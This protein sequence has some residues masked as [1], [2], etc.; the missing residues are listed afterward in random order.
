MQIE[1]WGDAWGHIT[2]WDNDSF[3]DKSSHLPDSRESIFV[4]KLYF[5]GI[6]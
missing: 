4:K 6:E 2:L 5:W 3:I 1:G